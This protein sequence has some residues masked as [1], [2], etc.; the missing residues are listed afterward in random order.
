MMS[1]GTRAVGLKDFYKLRAKVAIVRESGSHTTNA[2]Q[3]LL[4]SLSNLLLCL[5]S[6]GVNKTWISIKS[7]VS[8]IHLS[9]LSNLTL[10]FQSLP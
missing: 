3:E 8:C 4:L 5:L 9:L 6:D 1:L 7:F 2:F 10:C